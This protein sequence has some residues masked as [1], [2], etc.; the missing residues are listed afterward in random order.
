MAEI[1]FKGRFHVAGARC[2]IGISVAAVDLL[3][4]PDLCHGTLYGQ[5]CQR[6]R[7]S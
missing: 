6:M 5:D 1:G 4:Q 7:N 2:G 3:R